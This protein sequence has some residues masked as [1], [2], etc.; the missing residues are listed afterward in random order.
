M[1]LITFKNHEFLP[2]IPWEMRRKRLEANKR[3]YWKTGEM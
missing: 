1:F 3:K 2:L